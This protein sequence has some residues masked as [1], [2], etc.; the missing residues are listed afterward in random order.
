VPGA[1][2]HA[3]T[4]FSAEYRLDALIHHYPKPVIVWGQGFIFGGGLGLWMG[5]R[6]R[7]ACENAL[8]AMP[9]SL[10]GFYPDV[11]ALYFLRAL[12]Y[13][14][15]LFWALTATTINAFDALSLGVADYILASKDKMAIL[16]GLLALSFNVSEID[17]VINI[18]DFIPIYLSSVQKTTSEYRAPF[19]W[20]EM[21]ALLAPLG[22]CN[23][24]DEIESYLLSLQGIPVTEK[25]ALL[26]RYKKASPFSL[27][28]IFWL[29]KKTQGYT[30]ESVFALDVTLADFFVC[31]QPDF[32]E[33]VRALLIDKDKNPKWQFLSATVQISAEW[34]QLKALI[35]RPKEP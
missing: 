31:H 30:L 33:G 22:R 3:S 24:L 5:A 34:Q 9:E 23:S 27:H 1:P 19:Q 11:G 14:F 16:T 12:P 7:I 10:I 35:E 17:S 20:C 15:G 13:D 28:T 8:F 2:E 25:E 18:N 26:A 6:Y 21:A 4:Y 29:W 32:I